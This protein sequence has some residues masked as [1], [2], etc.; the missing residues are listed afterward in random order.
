MTLPLVMCT[1]M[2]QRN[3]VRKAGS[4]AAAGHAAVEGWSHT[5]KVFDELA[6][7][8]AQPVDVHALPV[9]RSSSSLHVI[10]VLR[11]T[12]APGPTGGQACAT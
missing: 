6:P 8:A 12:W 2:H 9:Q 5:V 4:P 1:T 11:H 3:S 7:P 10:Q